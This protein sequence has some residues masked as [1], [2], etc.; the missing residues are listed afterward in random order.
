MP[1]NYAKL[2]R[3]LESRGMTMY[4]LRRDKVVGTATLEKM[5]KGE[6][7][8]DTRSLESLCKYLGCQ[9]GDIMEYEDEK[10][11]PP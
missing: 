9:P 5:R 2:F 4:T 6:G 7:H 11:A 1:M 8:I 10:N 3:L